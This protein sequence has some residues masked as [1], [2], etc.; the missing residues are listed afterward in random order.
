MPTQ[1]TLFLGGLQSHT[2]LMLDASA[3]GNIKWKTPKEA[4]EM[5]E[6][7][8]SNDNEMQNEIATSQKKG[9]MLE[10]QS[11]D[12]ILAQNKIMTQQ[13]ESVMKKLS[14]LPKELQNVSQAQH[15]QVVQGCEL[16][17]GDHSNGQ[18]VMKINSQEEVNFLGNQG[19]QGNYGNY[20]QGWKP[21]PSMGQPGPSNRLPPQSQ[22]SL[23]DRTTK[24]E[25]VMQQF[26]QVSISNQKSTE[27]SLCNLEMQIGQLAKKLE[28]K[29]E[30]NFGANTEVNPKEQCKAI[31]IRS[32]KVLVERHVIKKRVRK[33][34]ERRVERKVRM[35]KKLRE[36]MRKKWREKTVRKKKLLS[37]FLIPKPTLEKKRRN[38]SLSFWIFSRN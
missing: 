15:Q 23:T 33:K 13:L 6:N 31:V 7:M 1:L 29:P 37:H 20:N 14:Q 12:A 8:T 21:H 26:V 32:G 25:E 10:L 36:K 35:M 18:C 38:N 28:D 9:G 17:G 5:I 34:K 4:H 11:P 27:A 30:K 16:C 24:L 3:G 22:P 19:R 2:K